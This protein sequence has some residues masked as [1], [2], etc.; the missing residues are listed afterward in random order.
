MDEATKLIIREVTTVKKFH[1][2]VSENDET[3][4]PFEVIT[5]VFENQ[6]L[7]SREIIRNGSN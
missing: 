2:D 5:M 4:E 3:K 1:G 6:K 7:V